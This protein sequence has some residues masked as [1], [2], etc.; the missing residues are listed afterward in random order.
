VTLGHAKDCLKKIENIRHSE[1]ELG[2]AV[3]IKLLQGLPLSAQQTI[4][5][6][7]ICPFL[8]DAEDLEK[9][10]EDYPRDEPLTTEEGQP[11][12][13]LNCRVSVYVVT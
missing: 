9:L 4:W 10:A 3:H 1:K 5:Q 7:A 6:Q 8:D 2:I 13:E 12:C 11:I